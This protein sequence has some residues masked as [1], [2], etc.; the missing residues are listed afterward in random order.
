[1][2][3]NNLVGGSII[4]L[5]IGAVLVGVSKILSRHETKLEDELEVMVEEFEVD[6]AI[7]V[8]TEDVNEEEEN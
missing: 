3:K 2:K 7:D 4:G 6:D 8:E 5:G 1:M